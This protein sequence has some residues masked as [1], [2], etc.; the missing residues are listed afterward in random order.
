MRRT[1][2]MIGA[3]NQYSVLRLV[4]LSSCLSILLLTL[5]I[6]LTYNSD[7]WFKYD[8]IDLTDGV[9]TIN[10]NRTND[11]SHKIEE[12][13]FGL[14]HLC[15]RQF[16]QPEAK[17]VPWTNMIR[18]RAFGLLKILQT[19]ALFF[20][21]F[22]IFPCW[23]LFMLLAYNINNRFT[24]YI[25]Y[26]TWTQCIFTFV[27]AGTLITVLAI[28]RSTKF[29]SDSREYDLENGKYIVYTSGNG[30]YLLIT[31]KKNIV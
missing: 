19:F 21:N 16:R 26:L 18:P 2:A 20:S 3:A 15:T 29:H 27:L 5:F 10:L 7:S 14:W 1:I 30:M 12:G 25:T 28:T 13:S 23:L 11:V 6:L 22:T 24:R 4:S 9:L 17:C 31:G 8:A